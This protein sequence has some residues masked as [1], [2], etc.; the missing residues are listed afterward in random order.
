MRSLKKGVDTLKA[1][2]LKRT[3]SVTGQLDGTIPSTADGQ[4]EDPDSLV[5]ADGITLSD[6]GTMGGG[7]GGGQGGPGGFGGGGPS[8]GQGGPGGFGGGRPDGGGLD[9]SDIPDTVQG[10]KST[11]NQGG[12]RDMHPQA[13]T[14]TGN[15]TVMWIVL[16]VILVSALIIAFLYRRK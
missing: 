7:F 1:F 5:G 15:D 3:E 14:Q 16:S 9:G 12:P 2:C 6:M 4:K 11:Q 8:G 13:D 10:E